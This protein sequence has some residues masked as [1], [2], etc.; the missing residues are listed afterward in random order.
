MMSIARA[1]TTNRLRTFAPGILGVSQGT[2]NDGAHA[3]TIQFRMHDSLGWTYLDPKTKEGY[4]RSP[5]LIE[6]RFVFLLQSLSSRHLTPDL[7]AGGLARA[8][9]TDLDRQEGR[10]EALDFARTPQGRSLAAQG[11]P[12]SARRA[13]GHD[14]AFSFGG[15]LRLLCSRRARLQRLISDA[16]MP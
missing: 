3:T 2:L 14:C 1:E 11:H 9:R 15:I 4:L 6:V 12:G 10:V 16:V 7:R 5:R 13:R 8:V